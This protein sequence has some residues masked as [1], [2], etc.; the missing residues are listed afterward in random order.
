MRGIIKN[1][2]YIGLVLL[3]SISCSNRIG[4][5]T[6]TRVY[7][8]QCYNFILN[9]KFL[10]YRKE[11]VTSMRRL[12]IDIPEGGGGDYGITLSPEIFEFRVK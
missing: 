10:R 6:C 2:F 1:N 9:F 7:L 4:T 5:Y 12:N 8:L 3:N 11:N